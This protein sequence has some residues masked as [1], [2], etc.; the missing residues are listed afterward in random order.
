M[1]SSELWHRVGLVRTDISVERVASVVGVA[2]DE[3][4][5]LFRIVG[6][7]KNHTTPQPI[8]EDSILHSHL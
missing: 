1:P 6:S 5:M 8:S 4:D 7:K 2:M 3:G